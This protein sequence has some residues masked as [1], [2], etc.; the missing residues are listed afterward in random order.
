MVNDSP[1]PGPRYLGN[2]SGVSASPWSNLT[3]LPTNPSGSA[4]AALHHANSGDSLAATAR[5]HTVAVSS[6][7]TDDRESEPLHGE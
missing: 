4:V 3:G 6:S 2:A 1:R 5:N 7:Q